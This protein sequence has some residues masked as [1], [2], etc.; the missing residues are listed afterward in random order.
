[1]GMAG[2]FQEAQRSSAVTGGLPPGQSQ[3]GHPLCYAP[4]G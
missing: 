1:Q 2:P 3:S 4:L